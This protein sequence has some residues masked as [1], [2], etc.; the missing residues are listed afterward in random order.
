MPL[1][2]WNIPG[3]GIQ[4]L[5]G[6]EWVDLTGLGAN[7]N[8]I[9]DLSPLVSKEFVLVSLS[10]D[11]NNINDLDPLKHMQLLR[12]LYLDNNEIGDIEPLKCAGDLRHLHLDNNMIQDVSRLAYQR[13]LEFLYLEGN[14][15]QDISPL[16]YLEDLRVLDLGF[17][18]IQDVSPLEHSHS[19][20]FLVLHGNQVQDISPLGDLGILQYLYLDYNLI[21]S[22][23]PLRPS[24]RQLWV[25]WNEISDGSELAGLTNLETLVIAYNQL[26]DISWISQLS[27]LV[28]INILW[29]PLSASQ[30]DHL[31][32]LSNAR[33]L[34]FGGH[35]FDDISFL[36]TLPSL[37]ALTIWGPAGNYS[38]VTSFMPL[39]GLQNL[40]ELVISSTNFREADLALLPQAPLERLELLGSSQPIKDFSEIGQYSATLRN[41]SL[42]S[43]AL[44]DTDDLSG[45]EHLNVLNLNYNYIT[46]L[47]GLVANSGLGPGDQV[48]LG[49]N[50]LSEND[51]NIAIL[52]NRGVSVLL[53]QQRPSSECNKN[54]ISAQ[55]GWQR[56]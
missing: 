32:G 23:P 3:R 52:V 30:L 31:T 9:S 16:A 40:E 6:I 24:L 2:I 14:L 47:D 17:N 11:H 18:E 49:E 56:P 39:S 45:L 25:Q 36:S 46:N 28:H 54:S 13:Q 12:Y 15:I 38:H 1:H 19:L 21:Q 7:N 33:T 29:N 26:T 43:Q 5:A 8:S 41:L 51:P 53:H 35:Y 4:D 50:C 34:R 42:G 22:I 20:E 55:A 27:N 37:E 10:L 44:T 48:S